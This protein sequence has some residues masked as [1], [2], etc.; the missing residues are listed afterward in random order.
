MNSVNVTRKQAGNYVDN[1]MYNKM[2]KTTSFKV[3][4][5]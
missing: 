4:Y 5:L 1:N 3:L 2:T